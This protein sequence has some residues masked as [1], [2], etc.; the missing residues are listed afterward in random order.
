[1][2]RIFTTLLGLSLLLGTVSCGSDNNDDLEKAKIEA[3]K[4]AEAKKKAQ[5][6]AKQ[7]AIKSLSEASDLATLNSAF[8]ALSKDLQ[9]DAD[10]MK[11]KQDKQAELEKQ[12]KEEAE[13]KAQEEAKQKAIKSLNEASDLATLNSLFTALS[14]DLQS[15]ADVM[16]AKQ[17]KE[18]E[19]VK[20]AEEEKLKAMKW[21]EGKTF[22]YRSSQG[23]GVS[24]VLTLIFKENFT[25]IS[26][27]QMGAGDELM[28]MTAPVEGTYKYLKPTLTLT[29]KVQGDIYGGG[30]KDV[31]EEYQVDEEKNSITAVIQ[32]ET[33][34]FKL[35]K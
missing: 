32:E 27:N 25:F 28:D 13:K 4:K 1:M 9:S 10:V 7:K 29:Y 8:N 3:Q 23:E 34:V 21:L 5:E 35:K 12:A 14:K 6:E 30:M 24:T 26:K 22:I 19:L 20:K 17:D 18:A 2:K 31:S 33:V 11:A 15:D 16:K